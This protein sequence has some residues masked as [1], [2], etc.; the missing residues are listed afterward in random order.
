MKGFFAFFGFVLLLIALP[1]QA[2]F[3][4]LHLLPPLPPGHEGPFRQLDA[5]CVDDPVD[6]PERGKIIID[7]IE[8]VRARVVMIENANCEI[9]IEY[10]TVASDR[11][12]IAGLALLVEAANRGVR[13]KILLDGITHQ[14]KSAL[15]AA[16]LYNPRARQNI[17]IRVFNPFVLIFPRTWLA[18]LHDKVI[19]V[20]GH[21]T[22][23]GGRNISN[24]YY[25]IEAGGFYDADVYL[26]GWSDI[27][28]YLEGRLG[29]TARRYF[30]DLWNSE[31]V[32]PIRLSGYD[33][34]TLDWCRQD[35]FRFDRPCQR[36]RRHHIPKLVNFMQAMR[37]ST[38]SLQHARTELRNIAADQQRLT[39]ELQALE[40]PTAVQLARFV[41]TDNLLQRRSRDL[42]HSL[43]VDVTDTREVIT[44]QDIDSQEAFVVNGPVTVFYDEPAAK[45]SVQGI[46]TQLNNFFEQRVK[47]GARVTVFS[48]YIVLN[49]MGQELITYMLEEKNATIRFYTNSA[50]S[51]DNIYAQA[52]YRHRKSRDFLIESGVEIFEF[53]GYRGKE[54]EELYKST[55]LKTTIHFKAALIENPGENPIILLG[56]YNVDL[57][58]A[59]YNREFVAVIDAKVS[60][61]QVKVFKDLAKMVE[62]HGYRAGLETHD[63]AGNMNEWYR[64]YLKTPA[65]KRALMKLLRGLNNF[66]GGW[67]RKQA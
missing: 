41:E 51:S 14:I 24:K 45:K 21:R 48:P 2:E 23:T 64:E 30:Y 58:S 11:I 63:A 46:A 54:E 40:N 12:S 61:A 5:A 18:R 67:L 26:E 7:N 10:Y 65:W 57:R 60:A 56:T 38:Q 62:Q 20:D 27:T 6:G 35:V 17:E 50:V 59:Y 19:I 25:G 16:A 31:L 13:V 33:Y 49:E 36:I 52:F 55:G 34:D 39:S 47:N 28:Y 32:H 15:A 8:A 42:R 3:E 9:L 4:D 37:A 66:T 29:K 1:G 22:M 53:K 43:A 44:R